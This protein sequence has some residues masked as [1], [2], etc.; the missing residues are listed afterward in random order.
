MDVPADYIPLKEALYGPDGLFP[1]VRMAD[2]PRVFGRVVWR[3]GRG[4]RFCR[5]YVKLE[6]VER[7]RRELREV[8]ELVG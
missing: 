2:V 5:Q 7:V 1:D 6:A 4:A 3:K 8:A